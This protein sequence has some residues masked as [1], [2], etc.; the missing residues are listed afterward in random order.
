MEF[1]THENS[2][3]EMSPLSRDV[4]PRTRDK[5]TD[6][7]EENIYDN[8]IDE[9]EIGTP[10]STKSIQSINTTGT[11]ASG[12]SLSEIETE[13]HEIIA[14][15]NAGESYNEKRLDVLIKIQ[16]DHPEHQ[17]RQ[18]AELHEWTANVEDYLAECLVS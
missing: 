1:I 18:V 7:E 10:Y 6:Y 15:V 16:A 8:N 12:I 17:A 9:N 5:T 14:K 13:L 2:T 11:N 3:G 4:T